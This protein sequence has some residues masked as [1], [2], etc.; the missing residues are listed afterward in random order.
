MT[1][2][3]KTALKAGRREQSG[4][5]VWNYRFNKT[6]PNFKSIDVSL[7]IR[8]IIT[9]KAIESPL[10]PWDKNGS[11]QNGPASNSKARLI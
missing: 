11:E 10:C 1:Q 8:D 2:I 4:E 3:E 6:R 7:L 9:Q 5:S